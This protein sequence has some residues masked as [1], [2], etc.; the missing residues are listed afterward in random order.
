MFDML[1]KMSLRAKLLTLTAFSLL[2]LLIA[3]LS[4]WRTAQM[5]E[6]F[7]LRQAETSVSQA[8]REILREAGDEGRKPK[9]RQSP[10]EQ[11]IYERYA[12]APT[13]SAALSLRRF[14]EVSGGF[15]DESGMPFGFVSAD[16]QGASFST[17]ESQIAQNA[18]RQIAGANDFQAQKINIGDETFFVASAP[19]GGENQNRI[20]GAFAFRRVPQQSV[21]GDWVNLL[22]QLFLLLSAIGLA[23]FSFLTWRGW[24]RGMQQIE[25]GLT[26]ISGDLTARIDAPQTL[27]LGA[28]SR[29][30]NDLAANLEANLRRE[31][32]LKK[33]LARNEKLAAL[34]RVAAGVAHEVRNPLASMK[35]KIQLAD[36][37]N[38][39]E[40]KLDKTFAVLL[41]ETS[42]LD[43]L[44]RK[45]LDLSRPPKLDLTEF[46]PAELIEQRL[47]LL[48]DKFAE[49]GVETEVGNAAQNDLIKADK[50]KLAQV[51]D[52]L[53]LNALEAMPDGGNLT[54]KIS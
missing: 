8:V 46:S 22:T 11:A 53:F 1:P 31:T 23:A 21:F 50:E 48:S 33:S 49:T 34:G 47:A 28:I 12:D 45:L 10:H 41:E 6:T 35:L 43:N 3:F 2:A 19:D 42:R 39:A 13:R 40:E 16:S 29:S 27:E 18:C 5:S 51:L 54:V 20:G 30:I 25:T 17:N 44:V 9:R 4:A 37:A 26:A 36:R 24:Q 14:T 32:E 38:F 15:C 7:A 52:N